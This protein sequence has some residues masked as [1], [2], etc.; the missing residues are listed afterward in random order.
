MNGTSANSF[1]MAVPTTSFLNSIVLDDFLTNACARKKLKVH[2]I[3][4]I[5]LIM[6]QDWTRS[7]LQWV[8]G[9]KRRL[10]R[11][12]KLVFEIKLMLPGPADRLL[13]MVILPSLLGRC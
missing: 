3:D 12:T 1:K 11:R 5:A 6:S 2:S 8:C 13:T 7:R 10:I 4:S 9:G